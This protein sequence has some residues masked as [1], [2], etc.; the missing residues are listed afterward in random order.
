MTLLQLKASGFVAL[1]ASVG[2]GDLNLRVRIP[3]ETGRAGRSD[4][5]R[6]PFER[7]DIAG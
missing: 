6:S 2:S 1:R 7:D 4:G 5:C 3:L